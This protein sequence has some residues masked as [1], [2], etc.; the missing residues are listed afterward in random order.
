MVEHA[1]GAVVDAINRADQAIG[2][3]RADQATAATAASIP[4]AEPALAAL[5]GL[6]ALV[7]RRCWPPQRSRSTIP[8]QHHCCCRQLR[9]AALVVFSAQVQVLE[10]AAVC[11]RRLA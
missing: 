1:A 9:P 4:A 5:P 2:T 3:A 8:P 10:E 6:L 11:L 7:W